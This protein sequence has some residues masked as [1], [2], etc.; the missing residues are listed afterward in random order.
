[1]IAIAK[2]VLPQHCIIY[3]TWVYYVYNNYNIYV[4]VLMWLKSKKNSLMN[5]G[6]YVIE[7]VAHF[8]I[9]NLY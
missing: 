8:L 7:L 9:T 6:Y 3:N 1:M 2:R 5:Y 4:C